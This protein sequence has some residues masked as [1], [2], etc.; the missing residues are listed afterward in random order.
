MPRPKVS[1]GRCGTRCTY[2]RFDPSDRLRGEGGCAELPALARV[3]ALDAAARPGE[4]QAKIHAPLLAAPGAGAHLLLVAGL[5]EH[6]AQL[7]AAGLVLEKLVAALPLRRRL[8]NADGLPG[9][10][11]ESID[12]VPVATGQVIHPDAVEDQHRLRGGAVVHARADPQLDGKRAGG[13]DT[14]HDERLLHR[15][16]S[17]DT[18]R[19]ES[20]PIIRQPRDLRG[21]MSRC[22]AVGQ[23][24]KMGAS[25]CGAS[26]S[27]RPCGGPW[28]SR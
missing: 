8:E 13:H 1:R 24:A 12:G 10:G 22:R 28:P 11:G 5:R 4:L 23:S 19:H 25:W 2:Y 26:P 14:Q 17:P 20:T 15:I 7:G 18:N 9:D 6:D 3:I 16:T 27:P 21:R